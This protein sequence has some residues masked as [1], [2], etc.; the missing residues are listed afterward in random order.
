MQ[1]VLVYHSI[2][3][4]AR[5]GE[6]PQWLL[7]RFTPDGGL[8]NLNPSSFVIEGVLMMLLSMLYGY[9]LLF[10]VLS[11]FK[12]IWLLAFHIWEYGAIP[13]PLVPGFWVPVRPWLGQRWAALIM[14]F[15]FL[16]MY[17]S[18]VYDSTGTWKSDWAE[19]L[20]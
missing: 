1:M 14:N 12:S 2:Y 7:D 10:L 15:I 4:P 9:Q 19:Y 11:L 16:G 13:R 17:C 3:D 6:T 18:G 5:L 20:P 8:R